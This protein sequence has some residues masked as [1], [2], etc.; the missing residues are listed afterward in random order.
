MSIIKQLGL[1]DLINNELTWD[2]K[3]WKTSPGLVVAGLIISILH[4]RTPLYKLTEYFEGFDTEAIFGD[5]V[6]A[7][8]FNDDKL[9][10][11]LDR[12]SDAGISKLFSAISLRVALTEKITTS[13]FH[14]DTTSVSVWG[15]YLQ[16]AKN[17]FKLARGHNKDG[18]P[19]LKQFLCGMI[20]NQEGIPL[21]CDIN[22]GNMSDKEWN[23][24]ILTE[25]D[26][27]I[28][29]YG[30]VPYIAD[31]ALVTKK[32][33]NLIADKG[34]S[35]ISRSP[36]TFSVTE[37]LKEKAWG[38]NVWNDLPTYSTSKN[39]TVYG[40]QEFIDQI[41]GRDYRFLVIKSSHLEAR[42]EKT[43]AKRLEKERQVLDRLAKDLSKKE[44]AC[45]AD[46]N[47]TLSSILE[48][49]KKAMHEI[50]GTIEEITK[51]KRGRPGKNET[52]LPT[53]YKINLV[54]HEPSAEKMIL[55]KAKAATFVLITDLVDSEKWPA[56]V[57]LR[58]YKE[59]QTV[60]TKFKILKDP[61]L[62][63]AVFL[64]KPERIQA[65]SAILVTAVLIYTVLERR[66]RRALKEA[67]RGLDTSY[68]GVLTNPTGSV[69]LY[70]LTNRIYTIKFT[71][72]G[73]IKRYVSK[74][75]KIAMDIFKLA[76]V[77]F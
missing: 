25:I 31:S 61:K 24:N 50:T 65:L 9:G 74:P 59:Q 66:V 64:K 34:L 55:I 47:A 73:V 49:N 17:G 43:I 8:I 42:K 27:M 22:S 76:S 14:A 28:K 23:Q 10:R 19:E 38:I 67:D 75:D 72:N 20:V 77:D 3:Q 58:E 16:V 15:E 41:E 36:S 48:S 45:E 52:Y 30:N 63:D 39:P 12:I 7:E 5:G 35:F 21:F 1:I 6:Q 62:L 68:R 11:V 26:E 18:H 37:N 53:I 71:D 70:L 29:G 2:S 60:E 13:S 51:R 40:C 56:H 69:L 57:I 32:N 54:I 44:L 4:Q 33:L 46:A